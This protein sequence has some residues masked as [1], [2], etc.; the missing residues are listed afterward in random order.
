[1]RR[2]LLGARGRMPDRS[3]AA[4]RC[5]PRVAAHAPHLDIYRRSLQRHAPRK[6]LP[7]HRWI[8]ISRGAFAHALL[9]IVAM[10]PCG[11]AVGYAV[12]DLTA[13]NTA[14]YVRT[15]KPPLLSCLPPLLSELTSSAA[16][17]LGV[18]ATPAI[19]PSAGTGVGDSNHFSKIGVVRLPR[20]KASSGRDSSI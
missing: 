12:L 10:S 7:E 6:R 20:A 18:R 19:R 8:S 3:G 4:R 9:T 11:L 16:K 13:G 1:M 15:A 5:H 14:M 2:P 17:A